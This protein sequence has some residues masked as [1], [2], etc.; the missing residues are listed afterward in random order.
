M[1]GGTYRVCLSLSQRTC[2]WQVGR[3][4]SAFLCLNVHAYGRWDVSGLPFSVSTYMLMAGGTYRVCLS[5]SQRTC[6]W[7][8]GR[9][10]SAFLCLN[11]H[12]YGRWD[13]SGLPFWD[14]SGLPFSV[15]TYMLMQ[16]G[17][18]GSA[19]LC[20]NVHAYGRWDVS[21]LPFS[22]STHMLIST[23]SSNRM[24]V[25]TVS[26]MHS[27]SFKKIE[28]IVPD[29]DCLRQLGTCTYF[30]WHFIEFYHRCLKGWCISSKLA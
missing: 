14:V 29:I 6:L 22:V 7:Q 19:F 9:I 4:G 18:I 3:I 5:L 17:R 15:S 30:F 26:L 27:L 24:F 1:A 20:L 21:G 11:A 16:V 2:L 25:K 8:V 13:V 23:G 10:G 12:A 28:V